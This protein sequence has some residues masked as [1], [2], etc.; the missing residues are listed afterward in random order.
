MEQMLGK[1]ILNVDDLPQVVRLGAIWILRRHDAIFGVDSA[2]DFGQL[3]FAYQQF[4]D[5]VNS[6]GTM[7]REHRE[8]LKH[9]ELLKKHVENHTAHLAKLAETDARIGLRA[10]SLLLLKIN[11]W[12]SRRGFTIQWGPKAR[13]QI[14]LTK[15]SEDA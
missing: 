10:E 8:V 6:V 5:E 1:K 15:L 7:V 11:D 3:L 9:Y 4:V 12:Y 14:M 2:P 13:Q